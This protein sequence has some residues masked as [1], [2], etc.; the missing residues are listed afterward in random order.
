MQNLKTRISWALNDYCKAECEYCPIHFHGGG[1]PPET[2]DYIR[3]ANVLIN[4]YKEMGRTIDWVFNGGEPLDMDDIVT[5]LK[6]CRTNGNSMELNTNGGRLWMDW[7]AIEPYV[8]KLNLTYH[9]WQTPALMKYIIDTFKEKKKSI[10]V[11]VPV[12]PD[13]FVEDMDRASAL[14]EAC[15]I[16]IPKFILYKNADP[17]GGMFPYTNQQLD[18]ISFFNRP[19]ASRIIKRPVIY[20]P[21]PSTRPLPPLIP[22]PPPPPIPTSKL[23]EEKKYFETTTFEQRYTDTY[24]SNPSFTGQL[25]N[26]GIEFLN[27][28]AQGWVAGS[29]CN[30]QSLGNIWHDGWKPPI[31]PQRCTMI[32]C[33]SP[34][35]RKITKFPLLSE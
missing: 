22:T 5:L 20:Q 7:W 1:I 17:A 19:F 31:A 14:E 9:Y 25:C 23:S 15:K 26:I 4:S 30:N 21:K 24:S 8:D 13:Y 34:N 29:D 33:I 28:G 18:K 32:S 16:V 27:I 6:L 3:V 2:K 12:R 10:N 35:D 11:N